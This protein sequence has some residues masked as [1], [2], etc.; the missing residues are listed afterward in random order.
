MGEYGDSRERGGYSRDDRSR[1]APRDTGYEKPQGGGY[2]K[3]PYGGGGGGGYGGKP[4]YTP[5]V[6]KGMYKTYAVNF[7]QNTPQEQVE[8]IRNICKELNDDGWTMR[9]SATSKN[10]LDLDVEQEVVLPFSSFDYEGK[11]ETYYPSKHSKQ[12]AISLSRG[13]DNIPEKAQS[14]VVHNWSLMLGRHLNG[15]VNMLITWTPDG[16]V[17]GRQCSRDTGYSQGFLDIAS[18][19]NVPIYNFK[20]DGEDRRVLEYASRYYSKKDK[21][22]KEYN[23]E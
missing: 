14:F 3:K 18:K 2:E 11:H 9:I 12:L 20:N 21:Q 10:M 17:D 13:W 4:K 19:Y 1:D 16:I 15:V 5:P 6:F 7:D 8:R 23:D 22:V